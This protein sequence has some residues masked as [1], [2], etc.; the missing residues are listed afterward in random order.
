MPAL[1]YRLV[2]ERRAL[3]PGNAATFYHRGIQLVIQRRA[4]DA[5][6]E[7]PQGKPRQESAEEQIANWVSGPISGIPRDEARKPAPVLAGRENLTASFELCDSVVRAYAFSASRCQRDVFCGADHI[8]GPRGDE[9]L[10]RIR[11]MSSAVRPSSPSTASV[12]W[13][14]PGTAPIGCS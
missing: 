5:A 9:H 8:A 14:R 7:K 1:K 10:V 4:S 6:V 13:P 3:V 12:C 2:P 11:A